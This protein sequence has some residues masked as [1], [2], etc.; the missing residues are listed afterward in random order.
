LNLA[1]QL[2]RV[3]A[4]GALAL[5][6]CAAGACDLLIGIEE[7]DTPDP[8]AGT[9]CETPADCPGTGNPCYVRACTSQN[10]CEVREVE[11]GLVI[12]EQ[13][14]GDCL[15][16]V[17]G[18]GGEAGPEV[19]TSDVPED[20]S[21]CTIEA[22]GDDG[23]PTSELAPAGTAC[24][25]AVCDDQGVC[26]ECVGS[27]QCTGTQECVDNV[28][29]GIGCNDGDQNGNETGLDCGGPDC[30]KC[31]TNQGCEQASDCLS[32]VCGPADTCLA[33]TCFDMVHN[34]D[35]TG[36]DCGGSCTL[37]CGTGQPCVEPS[38]CD[39]ESC[40][41][42]ENSCSCLAATCE[43]GI[44]N[45]TEIDIDCGPGEPCEGQ[46]ADGGACLAHTWCQS[47]VCDVTCQAPTCTDMVQNGL[48]DGI[49]CDDPKTPANS[50]C[51]PCG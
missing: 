21:P 50:G 45:G 38:D 31:P 44:E 35:E 9:S 14:P 41:C 2:S 13:T 51:D 8:P 17:C 25:D 49:D 12:E 28:C 4:I 3:R 32:G 34:G 30:A 36:E 16:I 20:G 42:G 18:S 47:F 11:P 46:C 10:L 43:D 6:G 48:E 19:D 37:G 7:L 27:E 26:V 39:S 33:P 24:D 15:Q 5:F 22:C 1:L 40:L 29:V 23:T